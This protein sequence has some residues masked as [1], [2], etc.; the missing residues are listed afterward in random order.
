MGAGEGK[1]D[2]VFSVWGSRVCVCCC[3][4]DPGVRPGREAGLGVHLAPASPK[5]LWSPI[6][7]GLSHALR[8]IHFMFIEV[9]W[10]AQATGWHCPGFI[11]WHRASP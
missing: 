1:G 11:G 6:A 4:C 7:A 10:F 3:G 8:S 2:G 9:P 5:S